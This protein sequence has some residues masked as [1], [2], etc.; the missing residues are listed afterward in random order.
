[1]HYLSWPFLFPLSKEW[2][3]SLLRASG[4]SRMPGE[5]CGYCQHRSRGE[6]LGEYL[7]TPTSLKAQYQ[8]HQHRFLQAVVLCRGD[9]GRR[10]GKY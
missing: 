3:T 1:M 5:S 6:R 9:D 7:Q 4:T 8:Y 2:I 10:R